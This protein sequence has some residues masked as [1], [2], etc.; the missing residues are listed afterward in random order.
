MYCFLEKMILVDYNRHHFPC[1]PIGQRTKQCWDDNAA[2][3]I[4]TGTQYREAD[5]C[6]HETARIV[7]HSGAVETT[8]RAHIEA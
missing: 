8:S 3:F 2:C 1:E 4:E 5:Q 6:G 7:H